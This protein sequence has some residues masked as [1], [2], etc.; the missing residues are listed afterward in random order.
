VVG[1]SLALFEEANSLSLS[2]ALLMGEYS[3]CSVRYGFDSSF[4]SRSSAGAWRCACGL[5]SLL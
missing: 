5:S 1:G 4:S 3:V 2:L